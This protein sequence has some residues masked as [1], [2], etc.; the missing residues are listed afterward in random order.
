M[1]R[2]PWNRSTPERG[3][4]ASRSE[5]RRSSSSCCGDSGSFII[6]GLSYR[7][8]RTWGSSSSPWPNG[9]RPC[10]P[11]GGPPRAVADLF[12]L[13][14]WPLPEDTWSRGWPSRPP[15]SPL[16]CLPVFG[17][18]PGVCCLSYAAWILWVLGYP[19]Q[20]LKAK[21]RALTLAREL[22]HPA[23]L[24]ATLCYAAV[25]HQF[26]RERAGRPREAEAL[27]AL[28]T[29]QGFAND[30]RMGTILWGWALSGQGQGA[31]GIAQI[32]QGLAALQAT[33]GR[34][35]TAAVSC[36]LAEAYG[37][38]G[39]S[40]EGLSVLAEALAPWRKPGERFY[41][42]ELY[43]LKGRVTAARAPGSSTRRRPA[44]SR[45]STLPAASRPSRWEL[46]AA[47]SLSRLWQ[48]Q[49][50]QA[51]AV[52]CWHRSTAGSPRALTPPI[53]RRPRRCW[54][55]WRNARLADTPFR[56]DHA[57]YVCP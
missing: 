37:G 16:P 31:E 29:E 22:A 10:A 25:L 33:G 26:R 12:F 28:A 53:C 20:A 42:A 52:S 44:F 27:I 32:R 5:R 7:R 30:W 18:D 24:A 17:H 14:N 40:E 46:R 57:G 1:G 49:G 15:R 11:P 34:G 56:S 54:M 19:D 50:K 9:P 6:L 38:I 21:P 47:M 41:E 48:Q 35:A 23:S 8:Q 2:R 55:R 3:S 51:E 36:T 45:P 13:E 43:R 39:Q 4:C